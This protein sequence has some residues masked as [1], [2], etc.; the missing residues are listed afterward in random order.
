LCL[1]VAMKSFRPQL[2]RSLAGRWLLERAAEFYDSR[3]CT[4]K[5]VRRQARSGQSGTKSPLRFSVG[6]PHFNRGALIYRPLFNL[7][8]H[9]AVEEIVIV[10]DGSEPV[11]FAALE[12]TVAAIDPSGRIKIHRREQ[13]LGALRTKLE[14]VEK[15]SSEWVLIL[16]SDNTAFRHY[17]DR[18]ASLESPSANVIYCARWAFPYFPFHEF[19]GMRMGFEEAA[20]LTA[21]GALRRVYIINDGNYFIHRESYVRSVSAV[22]EFESEAADVM[23]V[24]YHWLSQGGLLEVLPEASYYHRVHKGS[25]WSNTQHGS[26]KIVLDL[27]SRFERGLKWDKEFAET[28]NQLS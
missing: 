6:I 25:F 14:C 9:P 20:D 15:A 23:L 26:R 10:D 2:I 4:L 24:N 19:Q 16:D 13:N 18:L 3:I 12:R 1:F 11:E 5:N 21:T 17:L 27:F 8:N 22:A 28:L 7:L